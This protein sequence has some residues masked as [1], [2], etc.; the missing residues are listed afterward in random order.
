MGEKGGEDFE[1]LAV[2]TTIVSQVSGQS[3]MAF[4]WKHVQPNLKLSKPCIGKINH[5]TM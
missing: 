5:S 2:T 1:T 4:Q 3:Y